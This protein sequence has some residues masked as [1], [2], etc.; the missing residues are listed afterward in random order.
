M[1]KTGRINK[2]YSA[3]FKLCVILDLVRNN[4]NYRE[5]I[6]RHW[7]T[8][9]RKEEDRYRPTVRD[10]HRKYLEKGE[11]GLMAERKGRAKK[12]CKIPESTT[13][14]EDLIKENQRLK[15]RLKNLEME[16]EYLKKLRAL[17][18]SEE[19]KNYGKKPR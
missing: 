14:D 16:N 10:W 12:P 1:G 9:S 18:L 17:I 2:K 5:A 19:E 13:V 4:L 15:E 3:D 11:A 7:K 6:R 8:S